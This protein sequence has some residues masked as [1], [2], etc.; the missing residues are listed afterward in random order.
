M[1]VLDKLKSL[2]AKVFPPATPCDGCGRP[3]T[4]VFCIVQKRPGVM[5]VDRTVNTCSACGKELLND[6]WYIDEWA[7]AP[8]KPTE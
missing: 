5:L 6:P 3:S 4:G 2:W 8:G 7:S 1:I